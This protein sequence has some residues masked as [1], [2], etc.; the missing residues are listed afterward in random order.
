MRI[1][2]F[3]FY[4]NIS[5][6]RSRIESHSTKANITFSQRSPFDPTTVS[7]NIN[8]PFIQNVGGV[9]IH[10]LPFIPN[11]YDYREHKCFG[12]KDVF[13]PTGKGI[14]AGAPLSGLMILSNLLIII[15]TIK[16]I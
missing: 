6:Y 16:L 5:F 8:S 13:N 11:Y 14:G 4:L 2:I 3:L 10:T 7:Y 9:R 15:V 1:E 12:I